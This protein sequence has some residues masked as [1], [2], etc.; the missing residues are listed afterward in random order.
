MKLVSLKSLRLHPEANR[1]PRMPPEQDAEFRADIAERG[2]RVPIEIIDGG[3]I[4]DGR[5]RYLAA[6]QLGI[7]RVPVIRAP[8]NGDDPVLYMLRAA[9]KRRHL[10]DD[11]RACLAREEMEILSQIATRERARLGGLTGGRGRAKPSDSLPITSV[12]KQ[13]RTKTSRGT[14][15]VTYRVS[16]RRIRAAQQLKQV[17]PKLYEQVKAGAQRL[18]VAKREADRESKRQ[19]QRR[20]SR[21]ARPRRDESNWEIRCGDCIEELA[22]LKPGTARLAFADPPYNQGI[23]YGP[24]RNADSLADEAYL[25][26][27]RRWI[28]ACVR[29][30]TDDGS[31]WVM[32]SDEYADHF[33][34]LLREAGLHRRSWIK[35]YETFGVNCTN[36]FNRCSRHIFYC[37]KNPRRFVF[38]TDAVSR[39]S[40]RQSK[41]AD[42]RANPHGKLWDNVWC[43]PRLV[44]NSRERLPDF[45]TQ[46]PLAL[47]RPIVLCASQPG[48]LVIDPFSGSG[49]TGVASVETG[50]RF[51]GLE[52]SSQFAVLARQRLTAHRLG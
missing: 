38:N 21:A 49:T 40:D 50:R 42:S 23:D 41:Y 16:E 33:G 11:Q 25:A 19:E 45:P 3:V 46:L 47:V 4:V 20:L 51:I 44:E 5:S 6:K 1:V 36:N 10:T 2:I 7:K 31:L 15:A 29:V 35:W 8:L 52:K 13:S 43:I 34:L 17:A 39:P 28:K 37:V 24:G 9:T 26:W 30:L 48:D 22:K 27:C 32:I 14:V 12:G 18:T